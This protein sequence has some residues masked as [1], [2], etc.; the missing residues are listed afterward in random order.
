MNLWIFVLYAGASLLALK[1]LTQ[2]MTDHKRLYMAFVVEREKQRARDE[3][4]RQV[5]ESIAEAAAQR[6]V[7]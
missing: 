2:L 7:A 5:E 1:S 4:A 3:K 6:S